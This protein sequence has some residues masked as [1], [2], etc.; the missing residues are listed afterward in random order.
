MA[1]RK[2]KTRHGATQPEGEREAQQV[3]LRLLPPVVRELRRRSE[4]S[5]MTMSAVVSALVM[6]ARDGNGGGDDSP[7]R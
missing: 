5:A 3:K 2:P 4:A 1:R 7:H 6:A